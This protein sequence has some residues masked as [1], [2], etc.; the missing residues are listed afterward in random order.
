MSVSSFPRAEH[1]TLLRQKIEER[2]RERNLPL[3]VAE[4][5][6]NQLKCQYVFG[7]RRVPTYAKASEVAA[8]NPN[9]S[10]VPPAL[11]SDQE[12][13]SAGDWA[14]LAIHFQMAQRL[15]EGRGGADLDDLLDRFLG[16]FGN[17]GPAGPT[18]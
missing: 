8:S 7:F 2:L 14:E 6:L 3:E 13:P 10:E 11:S 1:I 4:R 16:R 9:A 17:P 18:E 15:E 5:A 12:R